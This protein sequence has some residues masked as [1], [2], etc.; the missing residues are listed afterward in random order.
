MAVVE[1]E[2][3]EKVEARRVG[4]LGGFGSRSFAVEA[5]LAFA[6]IR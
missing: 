4:E 6:R 1:G 3:E 2:G 5:S